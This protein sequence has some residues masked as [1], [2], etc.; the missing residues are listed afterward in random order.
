[1]YLKQS[2]VTTIPLGAFVSNTNGST[3]LTT[4]TIAG[5][6]VRLSK[7]G[8]A[9]GGRS[10]SE[11]ITHMEDGYYSVVLDTTDTN[12]VGQL[13]I[14]VSD[15]SALPVWQYFT[16][17]PANS[18]DSMI[19]GTDYLLTEIE[20]TSAS[21]IVDKIWDETASAHVAV[22]TTGS[23]LQVS[24][25]S[26]SSSG[27]TAAEVWAYATREIT[28]GSATLT[29]TTN[30]AEIAQTVWGYNSRTLTYSPNN[31]MS[32]SG[33]ALS[34]IRGDT[35]D[36]TF[37]DIDLDD[38][39]LVYFTVKRYYKDTDANSILQVVSGSGGLLYLNGSPI[40]TG[41]LTASLTSASVAQTVRL[42][43][44]ASVTAQFP[45]SDDAFFYDLQ[46]VTTTG[47]V[48]T[49]ELGTFDLIRD[50]TNTI[51]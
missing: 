24:A 40:S 34:F 51:T 36:Y 49:P 19:G 44:S 14:E 45:Y 37:S 39:Y 3:I 27:A 12:T 7:N 23:Y 31:A 11:V 29:A 9:F 8:G 21:S 4:L 10:G 33:C 1:M 13:L 25:T 28:G 26:A 16:V 41:S 47:S 22:D 42:I 2:T 18:Y 43:V 17:L 30:N 50:V 35:I 38:Y 5:S 6:S 48:T 15:S 20:Q 46:V 32:I